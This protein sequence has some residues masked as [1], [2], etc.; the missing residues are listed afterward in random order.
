MN[1]E[2]IR[3]AL[4]GHR[5]IVILRGVRRDEVVGVC[6]TLVARGARFIEIP[7]NT[8]DA[9]RSIEAVAGHFSNSDVHI[10]AGTVLTP[11]DADSAADAGASFLLSPNTEVAVIRRTRELGLLSI[12]GFMTPTEAFS[13][14]H[15]GATL[16]KCFPC[17]SPGNVSVLRSVVAAPIFAVGGVDR[18]NVDAYLETAAGV[19]VGAGLYRPGMSLRELETAAV[20]FFHG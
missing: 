19:G 10:G 16:L 12:P 11:E 4:L 14:L 9:L 5:V 15:A 7:L 8:P 20:R 17:M 1:V 13:A 2:T 6:E 18:S 3:E